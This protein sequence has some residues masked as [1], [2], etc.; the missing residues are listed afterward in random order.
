MDDNCVFN[1]FFF[2]SMSS[3]SAVTF[4]GGHFNQAYSSPN[5]K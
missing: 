3:E 4:S 1:F 2:G 5:H